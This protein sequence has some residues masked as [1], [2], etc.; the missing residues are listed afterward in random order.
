M[1]RVPWRMALIGIAA[2]SAIVSLGGVGVA[3]PGGTEGAA[4]RQ[5]ARNAV[6]YAQGGPTTA[7]HTPNDGDLAD[8]A[9][10]YASERTAPASS[11][12]GAALL[13]AAQQAGALPVS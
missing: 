5:Q 6:L 8:Q 3:A 4:A 1:H 12:S 9:A 11:V 2:L 13:N 7:N 10:Q